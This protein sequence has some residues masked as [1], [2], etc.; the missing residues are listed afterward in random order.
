MDDEASSGP[1][2]IT[3]YTD[4]F[5][6]IPKY[7]CFRPLRGVAFKTQKSQCR[8]RVLVPI[9]VLDFKTSGWIFQGWWL[10]PLPPGPPAVA[11]NML[12]FPLLN[13]VKLGCWVIRRRLPCALERICAEVRLTGTSRPFTALVLFPGFRGKSALNGG[14]AGRPSA[15]HWPQETAPT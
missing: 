7:S 11:Y 10:C 12:Y 14:I 6:R 8:P 9:G 3:Q 2:T 15:I 5:Y 4:G 1:Q 13:I